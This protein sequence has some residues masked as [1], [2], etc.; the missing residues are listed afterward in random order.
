MAVWVN[1][2]TDGQMDRETSCFTSRQPRKAKHAKLCSDSYRLQQ[3]RPLAAMGSHGPG[4]PS[5]LRPRYPTSGNWS[6]LMYCLV[7]WRGDGVARLVERRTRDPK[8]RGSNP[9][10]NT[11]EKKSDFFFSS[12]N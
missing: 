3:R 9:A 8:T 2:W 5:F 6:E 4:G 11:I 1:G 12:P 10:R 7:G